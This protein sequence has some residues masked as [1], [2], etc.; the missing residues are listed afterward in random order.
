MIQPHRW[1]PLVSRPGALSL[2][3]PSRIVPVAGALAFGLATFAIVTGSV[4]VYLSPDGGHALADARALLGDGPRPLTYLPGWPALLVPMLF[5]GIGL[6]TAVGI[7]LTI[8]V[9]L[10]FVGLHALTRPFVSSGAAF[11]GAAAGAGSTA[12]AELLGWQGGATLLATVGLVFAFVAFERWSRS[13]RLRDGALVGLCFGIVMAS[14]PFVTVAGAGLLGLRWLVGIRGAPREWRGWGP[15]APRG[16]VVALAVPVV[17]AAVLLPRYLAIDVP[18]GS[19]FRLPQFGASIDLFGWATRETPAIAVLTLLAFG[20]V[21]TGPGAIRSVGAGIAAIFVLLPA[22]LGGDASY[23]SRVVYLLPILLGLGGAVLWEGLDRRLRRPPLPPH[24]LGRL[25]LAGVP[26]VVSLLLVTI[27]YPTRLTSAALYYDPLTR[28][29]AQLLTALGADGA[30][31]TVATSWSGNRYWGGMANS[32]LVEGLSNRRA[33]GPADPA[34]STRPS[35]RLESASIWQVFAGQQGVENGALQVAVGPAG[36]RADPAI[37][38]NL[39]GT[40]VPL[41]Y[42]SDL[43]NEYGPPPLGEASPMA[44]SVVDG[45]ATGTRTGDR[46]VAASGSLS[47]N[48]GTASI[49]WLRG[50]AGTAG[51]WTIWLWPAYGLPWRD[52]TVEGNRIEFGPAGG[53]G[54]RDPVAWDRL[55]PRVAVSADLPATLRYVASDPRYRLQAVAITVPT[56][57]DLTLT[58]EIS[59]APIAGPTQEFDERSLIAAHDLSHVVVWNDTGWVG[60]FETSPCWRPGRATTTIT[61]YGVVES[62]MPPQ[63]GT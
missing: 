36:W 7:G 5:A 43:A 28:D 2:P 4:P 24:R 12:I 10:L 48:G 3:D 11:V 16:V 6:T 50:P 57:S 51:E 8:L 46:G 29:D 30:D 17:A 27:A 62:C 15:Y 13:Q 61:S 22:V 14:H 53:A 63:D 54:Y 23:Q 44:W 39:L 60:R 1:A 40:Y 33:I 42:I 26:I 20:A 58:V 56:R 21:F 35:Q 32:W 47:L 19:M 45:L 31:G 41:V 49:R 52:V 37:A 59:G 25:A 38:A 55:N 9:G 18:T 34:L